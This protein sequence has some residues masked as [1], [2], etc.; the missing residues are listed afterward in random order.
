MASAGGGAIFPPSELLETLGEAVTDIGNRG[1]ETVQITARASGQDQPAVGTAIASHQQGLSTAV[2]IS[3]GEAMRPDAAS[4]ARTSIRLRP[5]KTSTEFKD[6]LDGGFDEKYQWGCF[7]ESNSH[8]Q[9][10]K[11][12]ANTLCP[13]PIS[14]ARIIR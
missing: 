10:T 13:H 12:C 11:G 7:R 2:E 8:L 6:A 9:G 4:T 14:E 5:G 3:A 1:L